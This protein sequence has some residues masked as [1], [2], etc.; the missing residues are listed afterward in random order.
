[1]SQS[2][3]IKLPKRVIHKLAHIKP[4]DQKFILGVKSY[5]FSKLRHIRQNSLKRV[6]FLG[7]CARKTYLKP[8]EFDFFLYFP[9]E[10]MFNFESYCNQIR[11]LFQPDILNLEI[12]NRGFPYV[13]IKV[14][15]DNKDVSIDLVPYFRRVPYG[16]ID[17]TVLH[18]KYVKSR[19]TTQ[20]VFEI[21]RLKYLL[22]R[23]G[24]YNASTQIKG[25]SGYC[26]EILIL[27]Y[28]NIKDIP[29]DLDI[30]T[31][32][33]DESRN[34]LASVSRENLKRFHILKQHNFK[35]RKHINQEVNNLYAW[36][37]PPLRIIC[38][39]R[40][41]RNVL[42]AI[43]YNN[44]LLVQLMPFKVIVQDISYDN[45]F[46]K[47]HTVY[48]SIYH[49]TLKHM[50][51]FSIDMFLKDYPEFIKI[52]YNESNKLLHKRYNYFK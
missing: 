3:T 7:S 28:H 12:K 48:Q 30:L 45:E 47:E 52:P 42:N 19:L 44:T 39:V 22:K 25:F 2:D 51:V 17:R 5:V 50:K 10:L 21:R 4:Q 1:M 49:S 9:N 6:Y 43:F 29:S 24:L 37:N 26:C 20:L 27:T 23:S 38:S 11:D 40:N 32:P 8:N 16:P 13:T 35:T 18:H 41:H 31:D 14:S 15:Y 36:T 46:W 33:C 34:L